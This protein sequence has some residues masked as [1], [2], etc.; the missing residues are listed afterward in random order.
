MSSDELPN[1]QQRD[2]TSLPLCEKENGLY[3][4]DHLSLRS[5]CVWNIILLSLVSSSYLSLATRSCPHISKPLTQVDNNHRHW[6]PVRTL[7]DNSRQATFAQCRLNTALHARLR[8]CSYLVSLPEL[9]DAIIDELRSDKKSLLGASIAC[10]ALCPRTRIHLFSSVELCGKPD[11]DRLRDL[12][13][14]SLIL[15]LH[16]RTLDISLRNGQDIA[17]PADYGALT[18]V[19]SLVNITDLSLSRGEWRHVPD[20]VVSALQS[21]SYH[22]FEVTMTFGFRSTGEIYSLLKNSPGLQYMIGSVSQYLYEYLALPATALNHLYVTHNIL[23]IGVLGASSRT[24]NVSSVENI[25]AIIT[26]IAADHSLFQVFEW[27]I[28]NFSAVDKHCSIRYIT[29]EVTL[30][31]D[32]SQGKHPALKWKDLW[33]RLDECLASYKMALLK[34]VAITF[35]PRPPEWDSMKARMEGN[36]PGLKRLGHE[37]VLGAQDYDEMGWMT[38]W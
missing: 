31:L 18:V 13:T 16:F 35:E 30:N 21:R 37:L 7:P 15:A 14:L 9:L 4:P 6:I 17:A 23:G 12:I 38:R 34:R 10:K 2:S 28:S 27:W 25:T 29:F 22:S 20:T 5:L 19:E 36:F 1:V 32:Q 11:C 26:F 33:K 8:E 3:N 24:F